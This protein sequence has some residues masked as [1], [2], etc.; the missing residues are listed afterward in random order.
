M[1][2][3]KQVP[4][5]QR[6][7]GPQCHCHSATPHSRLHHCSCLIFVSHRALPLTPL[8]THSPLPASR[9]LSSFFLSRLY[10]TPSPP[11]L[12]S[13]H[14][15]NRI[16]LIVLMVVLMVIPWRKQTP[17]KGRILCCCDRQQ[18][19]ASATNT[20]PFPSY[21][22]AAGV[23]PSRERQEQTLDWSAVHHRALKEEWSDWCANRYIYP[24]LWSGYMYRSVPKQHFLHP[25]GLS[26]VH[27]LHSAAFKCHFS[28]NVNLSQVQ[29]DSSRQ[30]GLILIRW[31]WKRSD[32]VC[33]CSRVLL[34]SLT[35]FFFTV[36]AEFF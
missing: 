19:S 25:G 32:G 6:G 7:G 28:S 15:C 24:H 10:Y 36:L 17:L 29:P 8:L 27:G 13:R 1:A 16:L 23:Y 34:S 11:A 3:M 35:H 20:S 21:T 9:I 26:V 12:C 31:R 2:Q 18:R 4:M 30:M 5:S 33:A 14:G 22:G